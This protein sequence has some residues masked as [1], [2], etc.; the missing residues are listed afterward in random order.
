MKY[1]FIAFVL[2]ALSAVTPAHAEKWVYPDGYDSPFWRVAFDGDSVVKTGTGSYGVNAFAISLRKQGPSRWANLSITCPIVTETKVIPGSTKVMNWKVF[3]RSGNVLRTGFGIDGENAWFND[4]EDDSKLFDLVYRGV[5]PNEQQFEE[6]ATIA[7]GFPFPRTQIEAGRR[8]R[9]QLSATLEQV[10]AE[11]IDKKRIEVSRGGE[12]LH[13]V[14]VRVE[15]C[16]TIF[17]FAGRADVS[18][19]Y[20][21]FQDKR[22]GT[23]D[24]GPFFTLGGA[25]P[26]IVRY[27]PANDELPSDGMYLMEDIAKW[28]RMVGGLC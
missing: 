11:L 1:A 20:I 25:T 12:R 9:E 13:P 7:E 19:N 14:R 26:T 17:A 21:W 27:L 6:R 15:N 3:D 8:K 10:Y 28:S 18:V 23:D 22:A 4:G 24:I 2:A 5:C 16:E